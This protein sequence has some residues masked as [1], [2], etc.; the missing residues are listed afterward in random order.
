MKELPAFASP[1]VIGLAS[2]SMAMIFLVLFFSCDLAAV[3]S[4]RP[5]VGGTCTYKQYSGE[6]E[7]VSVTPRQGAPAEYEIRFSFHPNETIQEKF[8]QDEGKQWLIVQKDFSYPHE[9]F[10]TQ[11]GIQTG[12]R[13]PCYMKVITKGTCA[14]V[15]FDFP[16]INNGKAQ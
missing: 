2:M 4:S 15:L 6:A 10:L 13:L 8:A 12:K 5:R 11:Y 16:T 9:N 14:P 1:W 3:S 7:I